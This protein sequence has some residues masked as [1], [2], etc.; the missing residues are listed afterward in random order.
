MS[1]PTNGQQGIER[2]VWLLDGASKGQIAGGSMHVQTGPLSMERVY[3]TLD[4][5][6][7]A[8]ALEAVL[9]RW[10]SKP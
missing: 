6:D 10:R 1:G 8:V 3:L 9:A 7:M 4:A 2:I 5:A